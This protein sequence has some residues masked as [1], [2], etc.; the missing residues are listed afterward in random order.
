MRFLPFSLFKKSSPGRSSLGG[1]SSPFT[2]VPC[3]KPPPRM[4]YSPP[5]EEVEPERPSV[6]SGEAQYSVQESRQ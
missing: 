4:P 1:L 5:V 2:T 6:L 3:P